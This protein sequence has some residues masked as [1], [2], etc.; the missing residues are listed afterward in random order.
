MKKC[1]PLKDKFDEI[2]DCYSLD[3]LV[4]AVDRMLQRKGIE[5]KVIKCPS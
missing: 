4:A 5:S 1:E 2:V 3:D